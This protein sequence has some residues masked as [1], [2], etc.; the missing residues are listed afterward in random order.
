VILTDEQIAEVLNVMNLPQVQEIEWTP[1]LK[2][3]AVEVQYWRAKA[4]R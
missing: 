3:L 2:S 4:E 1:I